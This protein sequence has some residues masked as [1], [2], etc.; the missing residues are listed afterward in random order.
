MRTPARLKDGRL[1]DT[2]RAKQA[3]DTGHYG[4]GFR[5]HKIGGMATIGHSGSI[6]GFES[7]MYML[8]GRNIAIVVLLNTG[9]ETDVTGELTNHLFQHFK[10]KS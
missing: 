5:I 6:N 1:A 4:M 8:A 10:T 7:S 2:G 3:A 9:S